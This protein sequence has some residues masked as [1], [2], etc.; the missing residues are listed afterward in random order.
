MDKQAND[1]MGNQTVEKPILNVNQ[2]L[3]LSKIRHPTENVFLFI[4]WIPNIIALIILFSIFY[5]DIKT[6]FKL[7]EQSFK[8]LKDSDVPDD[9]LIGLKKM[10]N[11]SY[12]TEQ[13][14]I[15]YLEN[16]IG[17]EQTAQ[18]KSVILKYADFNK[19]ESIIIFGIIVLFLFLLNKF[20][21]V[22]MYWYIY[23]NSVLVTQNQYSEVYKAVNSSCKIIGLRL[24]PRVFILHGGGLLEIFLIKRFTKRGILIFTSE[25]I[26]TLLYSGDSRQLMMLIGRQIGHIKAGHYKLWFF[27]D[28]IGRFAF[29]FWNA[30]K[31]RCHYTA[32]R[33]GMLVAGDFEASQKA[34]ISITVGK[35]LSDKTNIE[36]IIEQENELREH[37]FA[38]I[39]NFLNEYPYMVYRIN[40]LESFH[41]YV[42]EKHFDPKAKQEVAYLPSNVNRF[43]ISQIIIHGPATIGD[44]SI[45]ARGNITDSTVVTG[46]ENKITEL[47]KGLNMA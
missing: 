20:S 26:E 39:Q 11:Q 42:V 27:K 24:I 18:Y 3:D 31:R 37:F 32:D 36:G 40:Q 22:L 47:N 41:S 43:Q 10:E 1:A 34:L 33:I 38:W 19:F 12:A 6:S 7:T 35:H 5:S 13:D 21:Y 14:F 44:G 30:W 4:V 17:K 46:N 45:H 15:T 28:I 25:M 9:I 2:K 16:V 29:G 8:S 23:G